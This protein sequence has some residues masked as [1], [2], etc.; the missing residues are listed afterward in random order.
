[1]EVMR[2]QCRSGLATCQVSRLLCVYISLTNKLFFRVGIRTIPAVEEDLR[3]G[4]PGDRLQ[5]SG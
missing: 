3:A 5:L 4:G 1:M 2:S